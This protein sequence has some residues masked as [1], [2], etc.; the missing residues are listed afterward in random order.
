[1]KSIEEAIRVASGVQMSGPFDNRAAGYDGVVVAGASGWIFKHTMEGLK[2]AGIRPRA[3]ADNN[4]AL[5]GSRIQDIPVLSPAQALGAW[6]N[7][8]FVAAIFTHSPLR[9][10]LV[11]LGVRRVVS[12]AEFFHK[13]PAA[14]L[15]YFAVDTPATIAEQAEPVRQA[16]AIWAD[17]ESRELYAAVVDWFVTLDSES[18]PEP[19]PANLTYFPDVLLLR[20]DEVFVD[21]GAFTGDTVS[22][23]VATTGGRYGRILALEPDPQTFRE[24]TATVRGIDRVTALNAAVGAEPGTLP[25]IAAGSLA[26]HA[27]SA[28]AEGLSIAGNV[29]YVDV[30]RLDDLD[31]RPTYVKMDIEGFEREALAG[32]RNLLA[33]QDTAFAL[34]L[35]HRMSDLWNLPLYIHEA[36][37]DLQ[38]FLRH[39]AEDW[40]ETVCYA[41]PP[42]RVR[43]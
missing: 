2:R 6:P 16:A 9:R 36:A 8:V 3:L 35:Y 42:D 43:F 20:P 38:L 27:V 5:W 25:F 37:P 17:D 19:L 7:A 41:I 26:S 29:V 22:S 1:L 14:F 30:T 24:L 11:K 12:Y 18:V 13:F 33:A 32:G 39:Y 40:S 34:T 10:Q 15:P 31:P 4:P 23:Y 21:C 28:G